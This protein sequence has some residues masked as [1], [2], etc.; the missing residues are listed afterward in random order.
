MMMMTMKVLM[1]RLN[2]LIDE[3]KAFSIIIID[4]IKNDDSKFY[5]IIFLKS[6]L[7]LV[8]Q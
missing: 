5:N 8:Y 2:K 4:E 1:C 3:K 7:F 6:S